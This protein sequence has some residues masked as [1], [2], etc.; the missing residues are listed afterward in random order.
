MWGHPCRGDTVGAAERVGGGDAAHV[1]DAGAARVGDAAGGYTVAGE[2]TIFGGDTVARPRAATGGGNRAADGDAVD[3]GGGVGAGDVDTPSPPTAGRQGFHD[4]S[5]GRE[6]PT[7]SA[8]AAARHCRTP[9]VGGR[10]EE[11]K[12]LAATVASPRFSLSSVAAAVVVMAAAVA[13][14][15]AVA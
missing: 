2:D 5:G 10:V 8:A 15:E 11:L 14:V 6:G 1:G 13:A 3:G 4:G 7:A 12:P 9:T